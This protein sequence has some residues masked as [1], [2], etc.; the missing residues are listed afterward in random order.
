MRIT[1]SMSIGELIETFENEFDAKIIVKNKDNSLSTPLYEISKTSD[2]NVAINLSPS[3]RVRSIEKMFEDRFG[4]IIQICN[5]MGYL[6]KKD[7]ILASIN[8]DMKDSME[9]GTR[10]LDIDENGNAVLINDEDSSTND[11]KNGKAN[12]QNEKATRQLANKSEVKKEDIR[13]KNLKEKYLR[14]QKTEKYSDMK[15]LI[16]EIET[17]SLELSNRKDESKELLKKVILETKDHAYDVANVYKKKRLF[18]VL[19]FAVISLLIFGGG[20]TISYSQRYYEKKLS[21]EIDTIMSSNANNNATSGQ[22]SLAE[23]QNALKKMQALGIKRDIVLLIGVLF[24][25]IAAGYAVGLNKY[26][27]TSTRFQ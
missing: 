26:I 21:R 17:A 27:V 11:T 10:I 19:V 13:I 23:K 1:L 7:S 22:A 12:S 20:A 4:I 6:A 5:S 15:K 25:I 18:F 8:E 9:E 16:T 14:Y 2:K 24:I 3:T